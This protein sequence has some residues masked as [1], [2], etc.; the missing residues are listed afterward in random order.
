[1]D[2]LKIKFQ[3]KAVAKAAVIKD[4]LKEHGKKVIDEVTLEQAFGGMRD[5]IS[6]VWETSLLDAEEGIRFRGYSIPELKQLLP[7]SAD[8]DEPLPEGIFWL[9]LTGD[10][11]TTEEVRWLSDEWER[12]RAIPDQVF[13]TLE[14]LPISTHPMTQFSTAILVMQSD[15]VFAKRYN[16]GMPKS[17]YW[18]ATYEDAMNL[19]ARLPLIAAYIYRRVYYNGNHIAPDDSLD[20][21]ANYAHMLGFNTPDFKSLMRLYMTIHADHEGG[22][23]SAH[24]CHLVG[25]MLSDPYLSLS[26]AM[27]ALAGP[28]HGLAN[29]EVIKWI[30][31]LCDS[32]GT[33][34]PTAQQI[35]DYVRKTIDGG[36]VVPGY[37]HAVLRKPDPRFIAQMEFAKKYIPSDDYVNV[38]WKLYEV[39]PSILQSLG[40]IKNP[41]P[42][43][44]AHSGA[45]LVHYGLKEYSYYTVMFGVSR[46]LGVLAQQCWSRAL[47]FPLER[48]KS[49]TSDLAIQMVAAS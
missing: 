38:V 29:Q 34:K 40:K 10:I 44:D 16:E 20:W 12:R 17:E 7:T 30:F 11:P 22:N 42:N 15:S 45:L 46:A 47:G 6:M 24:T 9:M 19:I 39:V 32:I 35:D 8:D 18:D 4:L 2:L 31:N 37:G 21:A 36:K 25:S 1:M 48:P 33:T 43:V 26:A 27:N 5:I 3:E 41:Y 23:G 13:K 28:L 14:T 49:I